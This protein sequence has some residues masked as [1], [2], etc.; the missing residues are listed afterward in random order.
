M[1][2]DAYDFHLPEELIAQTPLADRSASRLLLVNKEDGEL[3]HRHFTDIIDYFNPGDTLVL[4]DTRVIP[5]RLFGVKEDTGAKAE[6]L[7]LKNLG[8]D[9]WEALVKPGKKLKTGAV[10]I[11]S[12][13]L[14]AVIED[15]ADMGGRTL[16]FIYQGI[17]QE[18]LDRLGTMPLPPYIKET[19]DDRERYQTVYARHEGSAAAPTA[20]LHFTQELLEQIEAKGVNIAYI[21]LHVGLGTFRP[22]SVEK[23]EEHV[24]HSEY[25][26]MSQETADT[27]NATKARGGRI[28]AVGTTS[29]R[30]LETVGRQ[31]EGGP[32][33]ECSG[34]TDIFIYPGYKF[35]VVNALITNFHLPKSTLVMLV[36][37]LA[38]REHILA[39]YEEAIE[40]KY[41]FFSFG[42]A[43]FIY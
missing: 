32:L 14:R 40:Q 23:V 27:I 11:F 31:C 39:A 6:V 8:D 43:M 38:G 34:W 28:I 29:C 1:N 19:L 4:N 7:L 20:G 42:D 15:E 13:E 25:F 18:I 35:S 21:T 2:V 24:M 12:D 16:R 30:T 17:F 36:S 22:M 33:V 26:V 10:I 5:A 37:A 9:R 3:A 41:R